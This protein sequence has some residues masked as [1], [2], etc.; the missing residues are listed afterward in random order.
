MPEPILQVRNLTVH[1]Y[2]YAGIVKAIENVSFDVY[3]GKLLH[4]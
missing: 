2:T 3:K 4:S 1:F